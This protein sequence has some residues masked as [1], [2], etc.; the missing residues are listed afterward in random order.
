MTTETEINLFASTGPD[1][2]PKDPLNDYHHL[3][4]FM[5]S[6]A[7]R[8]I[9]VNVA[10]LNMNSF[11]LSP[12]RNKKNDKESLDNSANAAGHILDEDQNANFLLFNDDQPDL[13]PDSS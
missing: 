7:T 12:R 8:Q 13:K 10:T 5:P 1:N 4:H 11:S 9:N 2:A 3:V 6:V